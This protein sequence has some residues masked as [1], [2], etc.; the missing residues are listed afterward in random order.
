MTF[1]QKDIQG[2]YQQKQDYRSLS[3]SQAVQRSENKSFTN[4]ELYEDSS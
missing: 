4:T 1:E 2:F 3:N